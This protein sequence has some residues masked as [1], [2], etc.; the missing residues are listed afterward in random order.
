M[1][2]SARKASSNENSE[3]SYQINNV[4]HGN[5]PKLIKEQEIDPFDLVLN[6]IIKK[7]TPRDPPE[8]TL[9]DEQLEDTAVYRNNL[10]PFG[11][12]N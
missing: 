5:S 9:R 2:G 8:W 4:F 11:S 6:S 7:R 3:K 10:S 1:F 12:L